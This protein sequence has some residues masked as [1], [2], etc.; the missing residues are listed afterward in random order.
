MCRTDTRA[1][2]TCK[3]NLLLFFSDAAEHAGMDTLHSFRANV[4]NMSLNLV[5]LPGSVS[6]INVAVLVLNTRQITQ[7][8]G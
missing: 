5:P 1:L 7:V 4:S 8:L 3:V 6:F 2:Q